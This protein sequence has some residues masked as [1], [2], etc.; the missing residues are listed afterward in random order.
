VI[1]V[2][3]RIAFR[4]EEGDEAALLIGRESVVDGL[5]GQAHTDEDGD[6]HDGQDEIPAEQE[7]AHGHDG[8]HDAE[9]EHVVEQHSVERRRTDEG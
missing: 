4:F 6:G 5:D 3:P 1:A 8:R 7:G 2:T 9:P